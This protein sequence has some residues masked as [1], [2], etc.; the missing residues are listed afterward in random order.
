MIE[1]ILKHGHVKTLKKI[2]NSKSTIYMY[3]LYVNMSY[4]FIVFSSLIN[5][6]ER[7]IVNYMC[8]YSFL[9]ALL[10]LNS[11]NNTVINNSLYFHSVLYLRICAITLLEYNSIFFRKI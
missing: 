4:F 1:I 9:Y 7:N 5:Q 6:H 2:S 3:I 10:Y 11:P 8:I